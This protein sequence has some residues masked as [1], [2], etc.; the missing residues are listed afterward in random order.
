MKFLMM[1]KETK[2]QIFYVQITQYE[3]HA[4]MSNSKK[5]SFI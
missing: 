2:F 3:V 4:Q 5:N 1:Y